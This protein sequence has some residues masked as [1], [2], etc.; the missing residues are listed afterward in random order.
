MSLNRILTVVFLTLILALSGTQSAY[1][2]DGAIVSREAYDFPFATYEKWLEFSDRAPD[3]AWHAAQMKQLVPQQ[4]YERYASNQTVQAERIEYLSDG[5][6]IKSIL[7]RPAKVIKPLPIIL[8]AHGGVAQWGKITFFEILEFHR[9]AEQGYIVVASTFRGEGGSEG[10]PNLGV[11]DRA[12]LMNLIKM[13]QG[14]PEADEEKIGLW[15]FSRGAGLGYRVLAVTD[16][17]DAAFFIGARTD[18][19][20]SKR[21]AEFDE[22]VYP[23]V[24]DAYAADK[25]AALRPLSPLFWPEKLSTKTPIYLLH[26]TA[27]QRVEAWNSIAM[28]R[29]LDALNR[30]YELLL[31]NGG[32]HYLIEHQQRVRQE[33]DRWFAK[34]LKL[35]GS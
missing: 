18:H 10:W 4:D 9:L 2:E 1:A 15:G 14:L 23:D 11:G 30:P 33:M 25:D 35:Q 22:F 8:F 32:S 12:D 26:G 28:A 29:K 13:A 19:L 6:R 24:V 16:I 27:D 20:N 3:P 21:R 7:V 5:L 34:H 31:I 17:I